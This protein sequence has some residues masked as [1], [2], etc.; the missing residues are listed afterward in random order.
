MLALAAGGTNGIDRA[1]PPLP[2]AGPP[3]ARRERCARRE[4]R[5]T[6]EARTDGAVGDHPERVGCHPRLRRRPTRDAA[7]IPAADAPASG[8]AP[9][10]SSADGCDG[11]VPAASRIA[12]ASGAA[13]GARWRASA[14]PLARPMDGE[15]R[16]IVAAGGEST[17]VVAS[18]APT[19]TTARRPVAAPSPSYGTRASSPAWRSCDRGFLGQREPRAAHPDRTDQGLRRDAAPP[20]PGSRPAA[21]HYLERIDDDDRPARAPGRADPGRD[22]A[23]GRAAGPRPRGRWISAMLVR[24]HDRPGLDVGSGRPATGTRD[25]WRDPA[26]SASTASGCARCSR[27]SL[28]NAQKY[29]EQT[30]DPIVRGGRGDGSV[31]IRDLGRR[32][33]HPRGRARADLR[34]VPSGRATSGSAACPA[35]DSGSPS[36]AASLRPTAAPSGSTPIPAQARRRSSA[37]RSTNRLPG[38]RPVAARVGGRARHEPARP[39]RRGRPRVRRPAGALARARRPVAAHRA[40]PVPRPCGRSTT[41]GPSW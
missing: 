39:G 19:S 27:T 34:A 8:A 25:R 3:R 23:R 9:A 17:A 28:G 36:V 16:V 24:R 30:A 15:E 32:N 29:G 7:S 41:I 37:C 31:E 38:R 33:R 40:R 10:R 12:G 35:P 1:A 21:R 5:E 18:Y 11:A 26:G 6:L 20:R 13:R 22:A 14:R 4:L 2:G